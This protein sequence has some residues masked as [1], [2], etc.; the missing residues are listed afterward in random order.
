MHSDHLQASSK[1][2]I[3]RF[4][5][6]QLPSYVLMVEVKTGKQQGTTQLM[7]AYLATVNHTPLTSGI[8]EMEYLCVVKQ[9]TLQNSNPPTHP[10]TDDSE[11]DYSGQ[12]RDYS[13]HQGEQSS[14]PGG[15]ILPRFSH[16]RIVS[17]DV[18]G[19][20]VFSEIS[21]FPRHCIPASLYTR[22]VSPSSALEIPM[23]RAAQISL[24]NYTSQQHI[25]VPTFLSTRPAF[26][27]FEYCSKFAFRGAFGWC[28]AGL[29][30]GGSGFKSQTEIAKRLNA[31]IAQ[32]LP[33]L[34]QEHQQSV[35]TA[36]ERAKQVTMTELN[37]IIGVQ[38]QLLLGI[39]F[40]DGGWVMYTKM[41]V[42]Y[43][44]GGRLPRWWPPVMY[45]DMTNE[46]QVLAASSNI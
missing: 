6:C 24:S 28:A 9:T 22:L 40:H 13:P 4:L 35:A 11:G 31:I 36:V 23:L 30:E 2:P 1:G 27:L 19:R 32:V 42:T 46:K 37:A 7:P 34:A 17:D 10:Q 15:D 38:G 29:G 21:R 39:V 25:G 8:K 5:L 33:F 45:K 3:T 12:S 44:D 16:V 18:A 43:Q 20:R 41:V 26:R 14:V